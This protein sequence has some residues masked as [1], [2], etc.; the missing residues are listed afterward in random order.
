MTKKETLQKE[1]DKVTRK[2]DELYLLQQ[3][4]Q[5]ELDN[6]ISKTTYFTCGECSDIALLPDVYHNKAIGCGRKTSLAK[7]YL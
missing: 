1:L 4:I 7:L 3:E 5:T 2:I 6:H